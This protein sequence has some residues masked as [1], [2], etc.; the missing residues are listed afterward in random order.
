MQITEASTTYTAQQTWFLKLLSEGKNIFLTGKAGTGKSYITRVAMEMLAGTGIAVAAVAPTGI[1]ANNIGGQTIHSMFALQPYGI[2]DESVCKQLKAGSAAVLKKMRILFIDEISMLRPDILDAMHWTMIKNGVK[3]G[4]MGV[5]IVFVGDPLQLPVI[6]DD[7]ERTVLLGKYDGVTFDN[8]IIYQS[9]NVH[10]VELTEILR[11]TNMEFIHALNEIREGSKTVPYFR[12]FLHTEPNG[13]VLA[14]RNDTVAQYNRD[15][16]EMQPGEL[17][18]YEAKIDGYCKPEE[19]PFEKTIR[20][21]E[22]CKIMYLHNSQNNPLR[23]GTLGTFTLIDKKPYI[24]VGDMVF[25]IEKVCLSKKKYVAYGDKLELEEVGSIT[26]LPFKLAYALTI[27]KSQG[28][29]FDEVTVDLT[30]P[31]FQ[32]GQL[33]VALSRV[34]SPEGLRIIAPGRRN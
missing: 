31:V 10:K 34:K 30:Q 8:A 13:I 26:Q 6:L 25:H 29:T 28:L 2:L 23:N 16:L 5:Q 20:V 12:Q 19:F 3:K 18:T 9:L 33:Y 27:H 15:G 32:P 17:L 11:Q 4:L 21:K 24:R 1:A 7:N 14:P 22:G